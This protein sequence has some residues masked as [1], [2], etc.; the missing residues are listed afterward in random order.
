[1][2][3]GELGERDGVLVA[4]GLCDDGD[5]LDRCRGEPLGELGQ[6]LP[7]VSRSGSAIA[8]LGSSPTSRVVAPVVVA[9]VKSTSPVSVVP[10]LTTSSRKLLG[11]LVFGPVRSRK[12]E[13]Q[14]LAGNRPGLVSLMRRASVAW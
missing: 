4:L 2:R 12:L 8:C 1:M 11:A 9:T 7:P 14:K 5:G 10:P 6:L 3:F 13:L